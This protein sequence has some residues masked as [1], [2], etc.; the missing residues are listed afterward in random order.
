MSVENIQ[1]LQRHEEAYA[2]SWCVRFQVLQVHRSSTLGVATAYRLYKHQLILYV[3]K[4]IGVLHGTILARFYMLI[5][6]YNKSLTIASYG[7]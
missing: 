5:E 1:I 4:Q 2:S 6:A 3:V 7:A